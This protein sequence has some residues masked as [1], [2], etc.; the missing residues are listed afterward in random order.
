MANYEIETEGG[1]YKLVMNTDSVEFG[2][3]G[4]VAPEQTYYTLSASSN[5]HNALAIRI[6]IPARTALIL[7]KIN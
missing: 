3:R 5:N 2:G 6:Y 4:L 7:V 1:E